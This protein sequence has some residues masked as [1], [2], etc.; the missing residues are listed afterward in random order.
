MGDIENCDLHSST[1]EDNSI[2]NGNN[3]NNNATKRKVLE[4]RSDHIAKIAAEL[5]MDVS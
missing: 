1:E 3:N 4:I 2:D 5:L